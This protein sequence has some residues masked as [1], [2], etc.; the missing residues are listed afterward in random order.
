MTETYYTL[1]HDLAAYLGLPPD[2]VRRTEELVIDGLAVGLSFS[3]DEDVGDIVFFSDLGVPAADQIAGMYRTLLEANSL[4]IGTGGATL[5][6]HSGSGHV[7]LC[8]RLPLEGLKGAGM[9]MVLDAFMDT[10]QF[11]KL[12]VGGTAAA[13]VDPVTPLALFASAV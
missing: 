5:G 11:W 10:A 6:I 13:P 2:D 1:L 4:W 12:Y 3:G 8:G 7:L 9:A